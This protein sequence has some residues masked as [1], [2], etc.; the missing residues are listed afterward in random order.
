MEVGRGAGDGVKRTI[1]HAI[2]LLDDPVLMVDGCMFTRGPTQ[3]SRCKYAAP[4][5][6][7]I[8]HSL[9]AAALLAISAPAAAGPWARVVQSST[10]DISWVDL[11]TITDQSGQRRAWVQEDFAQ[12]LT[13]E[14]AGAIRA[15]ALTAYDC[16][17]RESALVTIVYYNRAGVVVRSVDTRYLDWIASPPG[18][19]GAALIR[20]ICSYPIGADW[21]QIEGLRVR[22]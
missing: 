16:D 2:A 18:S 10:G 21:R 4:K 22:R 1:I 8:R 6:G 5:P 17:T 13:G 12:P 15:V 14:N 11:E 3:I 7:I 20:F 9:I 19:V